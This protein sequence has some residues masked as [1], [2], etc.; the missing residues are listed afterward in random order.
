MRYK[1]KRAKGRDNRPLLPRPRFIVLTILAIA[2]AVFLIQFGLCH[3]EGTSMD[4]SLSDGELL[5]YRRGT[6][7]IERGNI[8]VIRREDG[9][10]IVKR[11][12]G[13]PFDTV[14]IT[15]DGAVLVNGVPVNLQNIYILGR[16]DA[17]GLDSQISLGDNE[18]FVLGDN[19][20]VSKDSRS[21]EIGLIMQSQITGVVKMGVRF[22]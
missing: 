8:A 13:L 6:V 5:L 17:R 1:P 14:E 19:R 4:P 3:V 7:G 22:F 9:S 21:E 2:I 12:I 10:L 18:Y 20:S 16:T 15:T 11:I